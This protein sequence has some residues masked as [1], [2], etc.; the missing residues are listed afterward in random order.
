LPASVQT[1]ALNRRGVPDVSGTADQTTGLALYENG[2]WET[3]G[4]TSASAPLWAALGAI[5]D[6]MAGHPLGF[7]NT[8]LYQIAGSAR[9]TQDFHDI[10]VGNN[11]VN[12]AVNHVKGYNAVPG[13]DAV[14]GL[15]SPNAVNLLPDVITAL[16]NQG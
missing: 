14:T 7:L 10:T 13:W 5:A 16:N 12:N 6:Q 8:A 2:S 3:A 9:Y 1:L 11:S 15:G 4:G